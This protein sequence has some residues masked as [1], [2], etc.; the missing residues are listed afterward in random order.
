MMLVKTG[1]HKHAE[2]ALHITFKC[3]LIFYFKYFINTYF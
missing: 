2:Q 1:Q 3:E